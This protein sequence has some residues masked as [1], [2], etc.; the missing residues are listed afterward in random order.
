[1]VVDVVSV[2]EVGY[3]R[4]YS[5]IH[6][7]LASITRDEVACD[8]AFSPA[9]FAACT[10]FTAFLGITFVCHSQVYLRFISLADIT[11]IPEND[12]KLHKV[13]AFGR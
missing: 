4:G 11:L 3:I 8:D 9:M 1:M 10:A 7:T 12:G 2:L 5:L 13:D 6:L